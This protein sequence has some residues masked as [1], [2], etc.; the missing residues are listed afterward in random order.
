MELAKAMAAR[1]AILFAKELSLFNVVIK[2]DSLQVMN[3]LSASR[4]CNTLFGHVIDDCNRLGT[5]L[6][7]CSFIHVRQKGNRLAHVL[8]RRAVVAADTYVWVES[9]PSDLNDVFQLDL[10][11]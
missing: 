7:A 6:K 5:S 1:R 8:V 9:L 2:G 11:Q 10:V 4:R 3:A